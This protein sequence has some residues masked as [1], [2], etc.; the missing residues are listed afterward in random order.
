MNKSA[1]LT[2]SRTYLFDK[3]D[4]CIR[5]EIFTDQ[6][7]SSCNV[8]KILVIQEDEKSRHILEKIEFGGQSDQLPVYQSKI[9]SL[10]NSGPLQIATT[11]EYCNRHFQ[12][13]YY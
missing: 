10:Q 11:D 13:N 7:A 12:E 5:Y 8:A 2:L 3:N 6:S 9:G 4:V 1:R